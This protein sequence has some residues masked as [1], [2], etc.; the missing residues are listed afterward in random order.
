M[1]DAWVKRL[2]PWLALP[3]D[4]PSAERFRLTTAR[5]MADGF[6]AAAAT[7]VM[8]PS[9]HDRMLLMAAVE[10]LLDSPADW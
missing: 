3:D 2:Q 6:W 10:D 1:T 5:L 7:A 9:E 4:L 8:A